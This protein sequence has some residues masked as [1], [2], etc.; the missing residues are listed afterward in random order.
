[1]EGMAPNGLQVTGPPPS[2]PEQHWALQELETWPV[3]LALDPDYRIHGITAACAQTARSTPELA[4]GLHVSEVF[5]PGDLW[6]GQAGENIRRYHWVCW[7][8]RATPWFLVQA[9]PAGVAPFSWWAARRIPLWHEQRVWAALS[10][11]RP[12]ARG[13]SIASRFPEDLRQLSEIAVPA[14]LAGHTIQSATVASMLDVTTRTLR[15]SLRKTEELGLMRWE[16]RGPRGLQPVL[17]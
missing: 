8:G 11:I 15:K 2:A 10:I 5:A 17:L 4:V 1:M 3:A 9:S 16:L 12:A 7:R 13:G 14:A 6:E